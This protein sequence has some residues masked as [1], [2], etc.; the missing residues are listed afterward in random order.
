MSAAFSTRFRIGLVIALASLAVACGSKSAS[1]PATPFPEGND[2][3]GWTRVGET[4]T[5]QASNLWEYIDGD[6]DRYIQAGVERTLTAD[7]RYK[8]KIETLADIYLMKAPEG[9]RKIFESESSVDSERINL[10]D[11]A[12]LSKSSLT[13]HKGPYLVRLVAYAEAPDVSDALVALGRAIER[14]LGKTGT[15]D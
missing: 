12:R 7:Y 14:K 4:R 13:F 2:V 9:A 3:P 10:G 11:G 6:A 8:E 5:F 1:K 15:R